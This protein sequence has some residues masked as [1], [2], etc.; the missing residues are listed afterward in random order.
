MI[1]TLITPQEVIEIAYAGEVYT[2]D[3]AVTD[4]DIL[5]AQ[6]RFITPVVGE[7]LMLALAND[8]YSLLLSSYVVPALAEY[9]RVLC[10]TPTAPAS[11][12]VKMR[13][14]ALLRELSDHLEEY[15]ESY[16]EYES[17]EN[18]LNRCNCDGG[19]VQIL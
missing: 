9:V 11:H 2:P 8:N 7:D 19:F 10:D 13:A 12:R 18:V 15:Q 4:A 14:K 6:Q 17:S 5:A 3:S 16:S 1:K